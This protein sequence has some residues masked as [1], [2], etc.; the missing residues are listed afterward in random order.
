M[1]IFP[2]RNGNAGVWAP[3]M[4]EKDENE[5]IE[6]EDGCYSACVRHRQQ[7]LSG[8]GGATLEI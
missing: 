7:G 3:V 6:G 4:K 8:G 5:V 1:E 2:A